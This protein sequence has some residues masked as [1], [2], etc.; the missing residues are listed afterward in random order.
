MLNTIEFADL[1][2]RMPLF[3]PD[4]IKTE[5]MEFLND[6]NNPKY[7]GLKEQTFDVFE[8]LEKNL[9]YT[10]KDYMNRTMALRIIINRGMA[11]ISSPEFYLKGGNVENLK[12][13]LSTAIGLYKAI[14]TNEQTLKQLNTEYDNKI[15]NLLAANYTHI[16]RIPFYHSL[17][18]QCQTGLSSIQG[19]FETASNINKNTSGISPEIGAT[20][21]SLAV[22]LSQFMG[23]PAIEKGKETEWPGEK[24][25]LAS[26]VR[27]SSAS[28]AAKELSNIFQNP[29]DKNKIKNIDEAFKQAYASFEKYRENPG[30]FSSEEYVNS[31]QNIFAAVNDL[32]PNFSKDFYKNC[33]TNDNMKSWGE[34]LKLNELG[35]GRSGGY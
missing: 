9:S 31:L 12:H 4:Q 15:P 19:N 18:N 29:E 23:V 7:I 34:A 1:L 22:L 8:A 6:P 16:N 13:F 21:Q 26:P 17:S 35:T 14:L 5:C 10:A 11:A 2:N 30:K 25:Y 33:L 20:R 32:D 24:G 27:K 28:K 3:V